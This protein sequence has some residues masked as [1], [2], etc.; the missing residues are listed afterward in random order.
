MLTQSGRKTFA[1]LPRDL[2][3]DFLPA[4]LED[5]PL[6]TSEIWPAAREQG[7]QRRTL[8]DARHLLG[9]SSVRVWNGKKLL[10]YWLLPGQ[11]L[12]DTIPAEHRPEDIDDLFAELREKYPLDP[13]DE[14]EPG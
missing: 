9:I 4:I 12:P 8:Q 6:P 13:L 7:L 5:G 1:L 14:D 2:A 3:C 11:K 10:T